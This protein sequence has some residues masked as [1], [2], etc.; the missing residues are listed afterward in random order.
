[1]DAK[2]NLFLHVREGQ[3]TDAFVV[4][5]IYFLDSDEAY[6]LQKQ[7]FFDDLILKKEDKG[8]AVGVFT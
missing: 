6:A 8:R 5:L 2:T 1:M 4:W 7:L 3:Q